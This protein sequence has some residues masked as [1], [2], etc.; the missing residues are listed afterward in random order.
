M[1]DISETFHGVKL[2]DIF[3]RAAVYRDA[4]AHVICNRVGFVAAEDCHIVDV[5]FDGIFSAG[6]FLVARL[7][8]HK[9]SPVVDCVVAVARVNRIVRAF[10]AD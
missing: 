6:G 1:Q 4:S 5:V 10:V 9:L 8:C 2:D 7:D 3:A